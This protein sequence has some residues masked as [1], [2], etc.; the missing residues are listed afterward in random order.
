MKLATAK[1][2]RC[3]E[4]GGLANILFSNPNF[5]LFTKY[6]TKE[7]DVGFTL[8]V[9]NKSMQATGRFDSRREK[10]FLHED[11]NVVATKL[12][13]T[14]DEVFLVINSG[15]FQSFCRN[16]V[17]DEFYGNNKASGFDHE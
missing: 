7:V 9:D 5:E 8:T 3:S 6:P 14:E 1:G 2:S 12:G 4:N 17:V 11:A 15:G 16:A 13:V 10:F